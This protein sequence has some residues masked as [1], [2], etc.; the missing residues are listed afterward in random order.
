MRR[1]EVV[2]FFI[3]SCTF[4]SERE[5]LFFQYYL[6]VVF[7]SAQILVLRLSFFKT[8]APEYVLSEYAMVLVFFCRSEERMYEPGY[9]H[10][11]R[12]FFELDFRT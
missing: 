11:A 2:W 6:Q 9:V 12:C 3:A 4:V 7:S 10:D 1:R 5:R 8:Y